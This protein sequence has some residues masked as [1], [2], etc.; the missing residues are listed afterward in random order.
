MFGSPNASTPFGKGRVLGAST[1]AMSFGQQSASKR[2]RDQM[3][4]APA[5]KANVFVKQLRQPLQNAD[6]DVTVG[7]LF[8]RG[9]FVHRLSAGQAVVFRHHFLTSPSDHVVLNKMEIK[10]FNGAIDCGVGPSE[11]FDVVS[12]STSGR[13][14]IAN[15][16]ADGTQTNFECNV[17]L[18]EENEQI[19]ECCH[20]GS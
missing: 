14:T 19:T 8:P 16:T 2:K 6:R 3:T 1:P 13:I 10:D 12:C 17:H 15:V 4:P 7:R 9:Q 18:Q 20:A 11:S 5:E